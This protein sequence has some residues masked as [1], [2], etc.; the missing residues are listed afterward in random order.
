MSVAVSLTE[1]TKTS[2]TSSSSTTATSSSDLQ[3]QF[4]TLLVAQLQN[5]DPTNPMDNSELVT[6]MAQISTLS[7]IETLNTTLASIGTQLDESNAL[8]AAS[9]LGRGVLIDGDSI[10]VGD[11]GSSTPFGIEL[12]NDASNV[13]V[14]ISD[15]SGNTVRTVNLGSQ[16]AGVLAYTWDGTNDSG[17][18]VDAG[19]YTFSVSA[20]SS[21]GG[22]VT[23]TELSYAQVYGV[24]TDDSTLNL[25]LA[26]TA[27][28]DDVKLII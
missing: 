4:L 19:T 14:T 9:L 6:Q 3:D 10:V 7:G 27:T 13:T 28:L 15:S 12:G 2:T 24:S 1:S 21:S 8:Q 16:S 5:Q 22:S 25:G 18:A 11:D 26:G 20:T 17:T 23:A